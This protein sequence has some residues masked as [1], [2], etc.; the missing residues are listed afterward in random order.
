M[1]CPKCGWWQETGKFCPECGKEFQKEAPFK[2]PNC[3]V[4]VNPFQKFCT[5]CGTKVR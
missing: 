1:Y 4:G 2:C 5:Y 3:E